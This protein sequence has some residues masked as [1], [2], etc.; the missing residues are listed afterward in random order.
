[1]ETFDRK[2]W[3]VVTDSTTVTMESLYET[4]I[5]LSNGT[6]SNPLR[7]PLSA[8]WGSHMPHDTRISISPQ[9]VIQYTSCL[10]LG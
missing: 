7:P 9:Q 5:A 1:L 2:L 8:K 3:P 10:V 4:T 6:I